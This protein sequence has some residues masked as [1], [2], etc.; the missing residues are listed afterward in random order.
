MSGAESLSWLGLAAVVFVFCVWPPL[1]WV[2]LARNLK[3]ET[4]EQMQR[5]TVQEWRGR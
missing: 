4:R 3:G 1:V 2:A 5:R